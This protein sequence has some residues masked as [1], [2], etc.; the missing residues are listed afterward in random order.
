M[1]KACVGTD[2]AAREV[3]FNLENALGREVM[4]LQDT[5]A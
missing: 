5:V 3:A 1:T 2:V 4:P